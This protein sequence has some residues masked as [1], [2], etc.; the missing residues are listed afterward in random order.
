[1]MKD[2]FK[3]HVLCYLIIGVGV[4]LCAA[5]VVGC[6]ESADTR[7]AVLPS[8]AEE[9]STPVPVSTELTIMPAEVRYEVV[10]PMIAG[11]LRGAKSE[12]Y[13]DD[14]LEF[15]LSEP[16]PELDAPEFSD[17]SVDADV[18]S[19]TVSAPEMS[20]SVV[21]EPVKQVFSVSTANMDWSWYQDYTGRVLSSDN[22]CIWQGANTVGDN[23]SSY[24]L[25]HWYTPYGIQL[26]LLCVGDVVLIDDVP[27]EVT[28]ILYEPK[29]HPFYVSEE[30]FGLGTAYPGVDKAYFQTCD[31]DNSR[32]MW[33]IETVIQSVIPSIDVDLQE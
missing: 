27:Y 29:D 15:C 10:K 12:M 25:A 30:D 32:M 26:R 13:L 14:E 21:S 2:L 24:Y 17:E 19:E 11:Y 4:W 6:A 1:M 8:E 3:K 31:P 7:D 5:G 16:E 22:L 9:M 33:I 28:R 20:V 23:G 18:S